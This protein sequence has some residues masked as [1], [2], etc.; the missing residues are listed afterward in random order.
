MNRD[1]IAEKMARFELIYFPYPPHSKFHEAC[2]Y[3]I[4]LGRASRGRAQKGLRALALS[5]S[6]KTAA[7]EA[8]VR[9]FE[10]RY[11][12][13]PEYV[14]IVL[15][16]LEAATT[17]KKLMMSILDAFGD[18]YSTHGNE[19]SLKK[20]VKACFLRFRTDLLIIDEVQHM[21]TRSYGSSDVTDSLKRLLDDGV[22]PIVFLGTDEAT[23]LFSRNLQLNGRLLAPCDFPKLILESGSDRALLAGYV[24]LLDKAIVDSGIIP[25]I[26]GLNDPWILGCFHAVS[27]GVIGRVSKLVGAAL[28]FALERD[29]MRIEI[30]DLSL[31]VDRWAM[32]NHFIEYNPFLKG[33][34]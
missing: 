6:G 29:A 30:S 17:S 26:S 28:E 20:R 34:R 19:Q 24:T 31:A 4:K 23:G 9:M 16:S 1:Q 27:G 22:V 3:L 14:P 12:R 10:L 8:F 15:I 11:P 13:T 32:N 2:D 21:D 18:S 33:G 25:K 5:G 7:A